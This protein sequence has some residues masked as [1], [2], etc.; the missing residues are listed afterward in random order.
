MLSL[1]DHFVRELTV[2]VN[3]KT[4]RLRA[5]Y[6]RASGPAQAE[7]TFEGLEAYVLVGDALGTIILD[8]EEVDA[9]SLYD[10]FATSMQETYRAS[11][12]HAPWVVA[13]ESAERFLRE[14]NV[15]GFS[16]GSSIGCVGALWARS[17]TVRCLV[18]PSDAP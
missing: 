6:P 11:G 2:D 3:A 9:L 16:L 18:S 8:I 10:E 15:K 1:H 12:G 17:F 13:R 5:T 7:G 14:N 4:L